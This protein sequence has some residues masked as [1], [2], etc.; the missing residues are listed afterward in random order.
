MA[1][2]A[3]QITQGSGTNIDS[4]QPGGASGNL[5][6]TITIGDALATTGVAPV[7]ATL[8]LAVQVTNG[9]ISVTQSGAWGVT[10]TIGNVV[11]ALASVQGQVPVTASVIGVPNVFVA[12]GATISIGAMPAISV[13]A[14]NTTIFQGGAPWLVNASVVGTLNVS[15]TVGVPLV[16]AS[17]QANIPQILASTGNGAWVPGI[18]GVGMFTP[19]A[20]TIASAATYSYSPVMLDINGNQKVTLVNSSATVTQ[21][22]NPWLVNA[23]LVGQPVVTASIAGVVPVAATYAAVWNVVASQGATPWLVNASIIGL[24]IGVTATYAAPWNVTATVTVAAAVT[25]GAGNLSPT[26]VGGWKSAVASA[27]ASAVTISAAAGKFGGYMVQNNNTTQA[28]VQVFDTTAAVTLGFTNPTM[29]FPLPGATIG[30]GISANLEL[31]N[32][33]NIANGIKIGVT[34]ALGVASVVATGV[35]GTIWY[36]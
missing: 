7:D 32:G 14:T 3:I 33:A 9:P 13:T 8:G 26:S 16:V 25:V 11:N 2:K 17:L 6:Q 18:A 27:V 22:N 15:A 35:S 19:N 30:T 23:S 4:Q 31:A 29:V 36:V 21:G 34:S 1:D 10:A 12:S 5:R 28:F 20:Y 24:P